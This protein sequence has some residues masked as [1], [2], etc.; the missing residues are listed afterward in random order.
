MLA[1]EN[2]YF[3]SNDLNGVGEE[4]LEEEL[5]VESVLQQVLPISY[6]LFYYC[7][8]HEDPL[9]NSIFA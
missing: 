6:I 4:K 9:A 1:I 3:S 2:V 7:S 8:P 5:M